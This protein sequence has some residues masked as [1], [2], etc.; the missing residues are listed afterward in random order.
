MLLDD[1][2]DQRAE[3]FRYV[4]IDWAALLIPFTCS[5]APAAPASCGR[6]ASPESSDPVDFSPT[7]NSAPRN[8]KKRT[9]RPLSRRF[10]PEFATKTA[11]STTV[12]RLS[13]LLRIDPKS[14]TYAARRATKARANYG[15]GA[16]MASNL[17]PRVDFPR[18]KALI[19]PRSARFSRPRARRS[20]PQPGRI[21]DGP[22][23]RRYREQFAAPLRGPGSW[24]SP[25]ESRWPRRAGI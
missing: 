12:W 7:R 22:H 16:R 13:E 25:P 1:R 3:C 5:A 20:G 19:P 11:D 4:P 23:S 24:S 15:T 18:G 9:K 6:S 17:H 10:R 2:L 14:C 21:H 8:E